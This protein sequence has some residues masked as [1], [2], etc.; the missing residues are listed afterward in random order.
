MLVVM[1]QFI[2]F[3]LTPWSAPFRAACLWF[4]PDTQPLQGRKPNTLA[5]QWVRPFFVQRWVGEAIAARLAANPAT[6]AYRFGHDSDPDWEAAAWASYPRAILR[7]LDEHLLLGI[8]GMEVE[9]LL[10]IAQEHPGLVGQMEWTGAALSA[11]EHLAQL[12]A[13]LKRR[14]KAMQARALLREELRRFVEW[15]AASSPDWPTSP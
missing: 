10:R 1:A 2:N 15:D 11:S 8:V 3:W 12:Y 13:E 9:R 7:Q 5:P 6:T 14:H 4:T